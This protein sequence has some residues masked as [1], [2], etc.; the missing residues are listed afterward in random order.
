MA[1][2]RTL[3]NKDL[4]AIERH[5][6]SL[7]SESLSSRFMGAIRPEYLDTYLNKI[8]FNKDIFLGI[9][10]LKTFDIIGLA[11]IRPVNETIAEIAFTVSASKQKSG[12]GK[13]LVKRVFLAARNHGY[14]HVQLVCLSNNHG[15]KRL[16]SL[17]GMTLAN[18]HGDIEGNIDLKE[19][20]FYT[21]S[22]ELREEI[23]ATL[24]STSIKFVQTEFEIFSNLSHIACLPLINMMDVFKTPLFMTNSES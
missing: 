15:M 17:N 3:T 6:K 20:T 18:V 13:E 7:N 21:R 14:T 9:E 4:P 1:L 8:D 16:A 12:L 11:E 24:A 19:P 23:A 5:F 2:I 22:E 10:D